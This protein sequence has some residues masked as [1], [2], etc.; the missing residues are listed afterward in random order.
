MDS[1]ACVGWLRR[2]DLDVI[3][4]RRQLGCRSSNA[5]GP[6]VSIPPATHGVRWYPSHRHGRVNTR[7]SPTL[8]CP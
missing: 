5:A 8:I 4:I 6:P 7:A 3:A 1:A 2:L